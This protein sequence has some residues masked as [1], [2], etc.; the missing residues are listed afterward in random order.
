M[1]AD[2][3]LVEGKAP[4]KGNSADSLLRWL[5]LPDKRESGWPGA[6]IAA[7]HGEAD[8]VSLGKNHVAIYESLFS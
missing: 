1:Q 3:G 4:R 2:R 8:S 5:S 6:T 7:I